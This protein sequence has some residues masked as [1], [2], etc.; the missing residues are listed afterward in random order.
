MLSATACIDQFA[1]CRAVAAVCEISRRLFQCACAMDRMA[2]GRD[3]ANTRHS[4]L[5]T[6]WRRGERLRHEWR[7]CLAVIRQFVASVPRATAD[8]RGLR[9]P[10]AQIRTSRTVNRRRTVVT[11]MWRPE[12]A[13]STEGRHNFHVPRTTVC[14]MLSYGQ[15]QESWIISG[16]QWRNV[17][18]Y[19]LSSKKCAQS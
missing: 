4:L 11:E 3:D 16:L 17:N 6:V 9:T 1:S 5:V 18:E 14:Y 15:L 13:F 10:I 12:V 8:A 19:R 2:G 7:H